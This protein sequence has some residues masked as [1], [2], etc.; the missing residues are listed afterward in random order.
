MQDLFHWKKAR[1]RG[2]AK[3]QAMAYLKFG[4]ANLLMLARIVG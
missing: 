2:I 4:S 1:Y 3:N